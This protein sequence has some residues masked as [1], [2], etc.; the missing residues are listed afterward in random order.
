[1]PTGSTLLKRRQLTHTGWRLLS[2]PY[3]E[4][5]CAVEAREAYLFELLTA[6]ISPQMRA[7]Q[8]L[9]LDENANFEQVG[10]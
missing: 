9:G 5:D 4:W 3:F 2:V 1:M 10:G 6:A 8:T 7:Y